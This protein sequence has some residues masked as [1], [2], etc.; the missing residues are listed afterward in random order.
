M[1]KQFQQK[2]IALISAIIILS[3][4]ILI[5]FVVVSVFAPRFALFRQYRQWQ[6]GLYAAESAAERCLYTENKTAPMYPQPLNNP[7]AFSNGATYYVSPACGT[8]GQIKR[9]TGYY[10]EASVVVEIEHYTGFPP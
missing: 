2:G 7:I 4:F 1:K 3:I 9:I 6:I 10:G 8:P 5:V